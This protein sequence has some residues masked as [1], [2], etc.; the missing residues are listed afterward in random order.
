ME[1]DEE[2]Y[3]TRNALRDIFETRGRVETIVVTENV[4]FIGGGPAD[5]LVHHALENDATLDLSDAR[6]EVTDMIKVIEQ[7][8]DDVFPETVWGR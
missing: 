1:L 5:E 6:P 4:E 2:A 8:S 7:R 3:L